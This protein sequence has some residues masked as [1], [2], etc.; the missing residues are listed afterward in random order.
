MAFLERFRCLGELLRRPLLLGLLSVGAIALFGTVPPAVADGQASFNRTSTTQTALEIQDAAYVS[1]GNGSSFDVTNQ[2]RS[3]CLR[4]PGS[5]MLSCNN[6]LAGDPEFGHFKYCRISYRC[7]G[8]QAQV[9]QMRENESRE[10]SCPSGAASAEKPHNEAAFASPRISPIPQSP[11]SAIPGAIGAGN[12]AALQ[13]FGR[14]PFGEVQGERITFAMPLADGGF[15]AATNIRGGASYIYKLSSDG[16]VVWR[17]LLQQHGL[18]RSGG[19]ATSGDYWFGGDSEDGQGDF[20][21]NTA[22]DGTLAAR[23]ENGSAATRRY[24][25]CAVEHDRSHIQISTVD[26]LDEYFRMQVPSISMTNAVGVRTWDTL[27]PFDRGRRIE[28]SPQQVLTCAGILVTKDQ[29]VIAAQQIAVLPDVRSADEI[30][31]E[32]SM[33]THLRPATLLV[34]LDLS[35]KVITQIR[36][37][38]SLG[39]LLLATSSGA[40]LAE[41]PSGGAGLEGVATGDRKIRIHT[42]DSSLRETDFPLVINDSDFD[43]VKSMLITPRGGLL[44]AVCSGKTSNVSLDYVSRLHSPTRTWSGTDL[45]YCGGS[46]WVGRGLHPNEALL[47]ADSPNLGPYVA[48]LIF[49]E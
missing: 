23:T 39:G 6:Q 9:L 14:G 17:K 40:M 32:L 4:T 3:Q 47:L 29:H 7:S 36:H 27:I 22:S 31:R 48:K 49:T 45:G 20:V 26:T 16:T 35:G 34:A 41:T 1:T 28:Q 15:I 10:L 25:G 38:E 37:D 30:K 12:S 8:A 18:V 21:Q 33:S 44:L 5:C 43:V 13:V 46:Y 42:F 11:H 24:L 19:V 2:L